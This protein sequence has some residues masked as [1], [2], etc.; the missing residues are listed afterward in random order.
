MDLARGYDCTAVKH[1][2][3]RPYMDIWIFRQ[4]VVDN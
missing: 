3:I 4:A 2:V 1:L